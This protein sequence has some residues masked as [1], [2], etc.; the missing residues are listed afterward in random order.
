MAVFRL[1]KQ[2]IMLSQRTIRSSN[3]A[4]GVG[5]HS[6]ERVELTLHPAPP[7]SGIVF[8]RIDLPQPVSIPLHP[9]AVVDTRMATT[10]GL[11]DAKIHTVEHLLSACAGLGLDNL[12]VDVDAE[13]IPILDGSASSF[14]YLLQSAGLQDQDA[15]KRFIRMCKPVE[16]RTQ[17]RDGEK[18]ARLEP[19]DGFRLNFAIEFDHP[20]I[21]QT[22]Q[23]YSFDFDMQ[24]Y[25]RDIARARTFGFMRDVDAL[26]ERGLAQGGSMENAIVM[27][28][29]RILN[30]EGLRFDAEFVKHKMLDA[31]GDLYVIGHPIIGAY[32]AY[33][34]GHAVNNALLRA[35]LDDPTSYEIV[36]FD[37]ASTAPPSY[38]NALKVAA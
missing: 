15:P 14:V 22:A 37:D 34:S 5:L 30:Q 1:K 26:R 18:W 28:E 19:H 10:L 38:R 32:S 29:S 7:N 4:V 2:Q 36:S 27:N 17:D 20:A 13:E 33:R 25:V 3:R 24:A 6:S 16:V 35:V 9:L 23:D 12:M 8:R 31:I 21:D 11:G